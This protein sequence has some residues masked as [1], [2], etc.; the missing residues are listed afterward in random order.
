MKWYLR[1]RVLSQPS[2]ICLLLSSVSPSNLK[3]SVTC[4]SP[5]SAAAWRCDSGRR[6][7]GRQPAAD[8][9]DLTAAS[10]LLEQNWLLRMFSLFTGKFCYFDSS[11]ISIVFT[12]RRQKFQNVMYA[13]T[14]CDIVYDQLV[15]ASRNLMNFMAWSMILSGILKWSARNS[16]ICI[17]I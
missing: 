13:H 4:H 12:C 11:I 17:F 10:V 14:K 5:S 2:H 6:A 16:F 15:S 9:G 1:C 8:N 7:W 3:P